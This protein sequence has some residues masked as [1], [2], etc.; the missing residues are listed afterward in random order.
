M[1]QE[2]MMKIRSMQDESP[3]SSS[4]EAHEEGSEQ[5]LEGPRE[6]VEARVGLEK[7]ESKE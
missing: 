2:L 1:E 5:A 6:Q 3:L 7:N 4:Q